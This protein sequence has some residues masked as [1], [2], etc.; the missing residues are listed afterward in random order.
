M[1]SFLFFVVCRD[2]YDLNLNYSQFQQL[3]VNKTQTILD[4]QNNKRRPRLRIIE[5][6]ITPN[7]LQPVAIM[8]LKA[9]ASQLGV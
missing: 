6:I 7:H 4:Q 2:I 1:L 8:D 5:S 3:K 9:L